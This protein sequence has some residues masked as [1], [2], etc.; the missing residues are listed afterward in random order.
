[1]TLSQAKEYWE[2]PKLMKR[3]GGILRAFGLGSIS[4]LVLWIHY[5]LSIEL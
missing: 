3:Q 2:L 4:L 1:M 5:Y